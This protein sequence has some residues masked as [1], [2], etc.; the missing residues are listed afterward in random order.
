MTNK[1]IIIL[2][3]GVGLGSFRMAENINRILKK[4]GYE[5]L[6]LNLHEFE[7]S[8]IV[9]FLEKLYV[10]LLANFPSLWEWLSKQEWLVK[11]ILPLRTKI[12]TKNYSNILNEILMFQPDLIISTN[13]FCSAIVSYLKTESLYKGIFC[14]AFS[15]FYLHKFWLYK[16]VDYYLANTDEQKQDMIEM[17]IYRNKIFVCGVPIIY[18]QIKEKKELTK[19]CK[20]KDNEKVVLISSGSLGLG[21]DESLIDAILQ[22]SQIKI[23]ILCGKNK[24]LYEYFATKYKNNNVLVLED[25]N[26]PEDF[27]QLADI[28]ISK[29]GTFSVVEALYF[30]V[31]V[32]V[33]HLLP[34]FEQYNYNYLLEKGLIMP[35][36]INIIESVL[37]ELELGSFKKS[38]MNNPQI[39]S[40]VNTQQVVIDSVAEM[41]K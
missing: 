37:E 17:G 8:K 7:N 36:P 26:Y 34:G 5:I 30:R 10:F 2:Y 12:A 24:S 32:L 25:I 9:N 22:K 14:V 18:Q 16:N 31:P 21:M 38:V 29:A 40:L 39:K 15:D 4:V 11:Q 3:A 6:L 19:T 23:I 35:E 1:K 27:Y 28:F 13:Y 20:V 33:T 41:L